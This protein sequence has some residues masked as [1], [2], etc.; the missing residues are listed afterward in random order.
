[1]ADNTNKPDSIFS[2]VL[3]AINGGKRR[4]PEIAQTAHFQGQTQGGL[5][6]KDNNAVENIQQ[7]YLDWQVN[8]IAHN[9]YQRTLYFDTD[10][11]SAYQD[12]R[13]MDM[14]P[15]ISAALNIIRD[16]CLEANTIIPL[17]NGEKATIEELYNSN[18]KDFYVYSYNAVD[19]KFE[20][21]LCQRVVYKGE[22]EVYKIIF[23]D[24]SY[25]EATSEH[26]WLKKGINEYI[27][28]CELKEGVSIEPFYN[29]IS[30]ENDRIQGY[31]MLLENGK[32]EYTHRIIKR[33]VYP[34]EKGVAHHKDIKK[35]NNDPSN[36]QVMTWKEHQYLHHKLNSERWK[37]NDEYSQKMRKIFSEVNSANGQYWSNEEW[38]NKRVDA[39]KNRTKEKYSTFTSEELKEIFSFPDEA[40]GMFGNGWKLIGEKNGRFLSEKRR[41]FLL[42]ELIDAY[43]KTDSI[44]S[45]C[46]LLNTTRRILYKSQAYKNLNI[47]RWE[48]IGFLTQEISIENIEMTCQKYLG[49]LILENSLSFICKE[50]NWV[51]KK[52]STFLKNNGY[53]K[54]TDFVSKYSSKE[55][56]FDIIKS[57]VKV[58]GNISLSDICDLSDFE[59]KQIDG[60]IQRSQYKNFSGLKASINHKVKSVE[61][62]GK[63]KTYDLVNVGKYHNFAILTSNGTGVISHNC[64]TRN[65]KGNILEIYSENA[66]VKEVL[67]DLFNKRLNIEFNLKLWIRDLIK[68]GDYMVHLHVDAKDGIYNFRTLPV[69]EMHR[70]EGYEG[71]P[72]AVRFRW[73]TTNDYFEEWQIAHF[74]ILEDT[75]KIPY[76]RSILDPARK[77][78][79]QLQL[80]E[81]SMLVY[82]ITRAPERRVFYIEVGNLEDADVKQYVMKIQNQLKKQPI[83]DQKTGNINLKYNPM[84]ITED[85]FIPIRGDKS[86]RIDTLPGA[87][88]LGDI[89]DIE[90]LQNK[91]FASLQVPKAYLNYAESLPG[92]S[93]LSQADLRF[94]RTINSI[95]EVVLMELRRIANIHLY[96]AGFKDD[97]DNFSLSL[98]NPSTQ[99]E[100][101]KLETMKA[102]LEVAKEYYAPD[103]TSF[104]SWTWVMENIL[105]FSK[106]DIKLILKQK[107]VEKK[108]F[109]EID[110]AVDTYKKIGLFNALDAKYE[111]P[112][113]VAKMGA[114]GEGDGGAGGGDGGA[115]GAGEMGN[116][117]I[118]SQLGGMGGG[119]AG[120]EMGGAGAGGAG[121]M[122]GA[123]EAAPT[124]EEIP[125]A[126]LRQI[127]LK[128]ILKESDNRFEN[129]LEDLLGKDE[130]MIEED[131]SLLQN[132]Q[133]LNYKTKR[134]LERMQ[135][136][137]DSKT[138][139]NVEE[140]VL[141][142][143]KE[144]I[145]LFSN[146]E[147]LINQTNDMM[148]VLENMF[149]PK[150]AIEDVID[151]SE[152]EINEES[153]NGFN[154]HQDDD[155]ETRSHDN[156]IGDDNNGFDA[157]QDDDQEA[158]SHDNIIGSNNGLMTANQ[159]DQDKESTMTKQSDTG[160]GLDAHQE[161]GQE[162]NTM[163]KME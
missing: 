147:K 91:L 60:L 71:K 9:L 105:G 26:L 78:W 13:A 83:V 136:N 84:N 152:F 19:K 149:K 90:Y 118:G 2:G 65:E 141:Q 107:K 115:G 21:G 151:E 36:L 43:I 3:D 67:K 25:V 12:Y 160:T 116:M 103:A 112:G 135:Q 85:F 93:T 108:I 1:M 28:T 86:S 128:K 48:D 62:I 111:I 88:N 153:N 109:A 72:D 23:D 148:L 44:E 145:P 27:K 5:M 161:D 162:S 42:E 54:W 24:D 61:F 7:Q 63:R 125:L 15:E 117:D 140:K 75:K 121:E 46:E 110:S 53:G 34:N 55:S 114:E 49:K 51:P 38:R 14:S 79:K 92:G 104:A 137:I 33:E 138:E 70:E 156:I 22:Q 124:E 17:L 132:N 154:A 69:E 89:Q 32:W 29:K 10:R 57:A 58:H 133:K 80:A 158:R 37:N 52:V 97:V 122:G 95:Q 6:Q 64:L 106:I 74:R 4:T 126:E 50:N 134:L 45:A 96:F 68:Y 120:G 77:L 146:N 66:R 163:Y 143:T 76:G 87:S 16:E 139:G 73:E 119:E 113:A 41:E 56:V 20:P 131:S 82:R 123:P 100:L 94:A 155:Q 159:D 30:D 18:R 142:E 102:R 81:D 40:N 35:L 98:T 8:K 47:A 144:I 130:Q 157:H 101:L 129:Y 99:Q 59:Y 150:E 39:I 127:K 31:E 11:I